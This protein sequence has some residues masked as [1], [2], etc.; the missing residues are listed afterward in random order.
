AVHGAG[1]RRRRRSGGAVWWHD[2]GAQRRRCM[3]QASKGPGGGAGDDDGRNSP[4]WSG[5]TDEAQGAGVQ[6]ARQWCRRRRESKLAWLERLE[7]TTTMVKTRLAGAARL[8]V[9]HKPKPCKL[10]VGK[11]LQATNTWL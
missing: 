7:Q 9:S 1:A 5:A 2:G 11:I 8:R 10:G 6:G 4:G 3:R